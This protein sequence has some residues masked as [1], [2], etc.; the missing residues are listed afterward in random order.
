[1]QWLISQIWILLAV[2]GF[3][4][5]IL[6]LALRGLMGGNKLRRATV[7]RDVARTELGQA[8]AEIDALYAS[9]RK[10]KEENAG[11]GAV[12]NTQETDA[13][14]AEIGVRDQRLSELEAALQSARDDLE[15]AQQAHA[16]AETNADGIKATGAALAGAAVGAVLGGDDDKVR[17]LEER[18][19]WL[20]ERIQALEADIETL[21]QASAEVV[22][23]APVESDEAETSINLTKLEWQNTY[24]RQR[25]EALENRMTVTPVLAVDNEAEAAEAEAA[26]VPVVEANPQQDE[27]MAR[28]RWR[29]RYLEGRLAYYEEEANAEDLAEAT[30]EPEPI[31]EEVMEDAVEEAPAEEPQVDDAGDVEVEEETSE[32]EVSE[33]DPEVVEEAESEPAEEAPQE[34]AAPEETAEE[35]PAEAVLRSLEGDEAESEEAEVP[36]EAVSDAGEAA[37]PEAFNEPKDGG[38]DLTAIGGIGP[39]IAEVLNGLGIWT[40]A[41]IASWT[42]ENAAWVEE[43]LSFKGRVEREQWIAQAKALIE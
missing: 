21:G 33:A 30:P 17:E 39:R 26:E 16:S 7:E 6:G 31:Q 35:H 3:L 43:H 9:Q 27:E 12:P 42:P 34:E 36:E 25:V 10:L 5:L 38:D 37:Q 14:K 13:L 20:E 32:T 41:Q 22:A 19:V 4:G 40:Y 29:N 8:R 18:N 23:P 11:Q 1:M 2:A 15:V 24:L 28:L